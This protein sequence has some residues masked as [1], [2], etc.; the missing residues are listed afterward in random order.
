MKSETADPLVGRL[1]EIAGDTPELRV[2]ARLYEAILPICRDARMESFEF[3]ADAAGMQQA[4][5]SGA[6]ILTAGEFEVELQ[7]TE[8][9]MLDLLVSIEAMEFA[10]RGGRRWRFWDTGQ[11]PWSAGELAA[12]DKLRGSA[13]CL[14]IRCQTGQL[15]LGSLLALAADGDRAGFEQV[16]D[17]PDQEADLL[18]TLSHHAIKPLLREVRKKA[19]QQ[20]EAGWQKG[21]CYVCGAEATLGEL[22]DNAQQKHLR[23]AQCGADWHHPRLQCFHCG[24]E[25]HRK[26]KYLYAEGKEHRRIE[27]CDE[28]H[29]YLK[30]IT[31]FTPTAPELVAVED[32]ATLDL[33]FLAQVHGYRKPQQA[34]HGEQVT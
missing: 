32:L 22:Q 25:D 12:L 33:D 28:C 29:S 1:R 14:R 27:V 24:N 4:L 20:Q 9:L 19:P 16:L 21:N 26:L 10:G 2:T 13:A 23:C 18:W 5:E 34:P 6:P 17:A 3:L 15:D 8:K 11:E 30:V 31:A 7:E